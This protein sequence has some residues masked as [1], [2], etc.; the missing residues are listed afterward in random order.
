MN[1]ENKLS[2][3]T[4]RRLSVLSERIL[5]EWERRAVE[6]IPSAR[7]QSRLVLRD[8]LPAFMKKLASV[9]E[10]QES[11]NPVDKVAGPS[12]EHGQQRAE[13][14]EYSIEEVLREYHLLRKV[15]VEILSKE[16]GLVDSD[17]NLIDEALDEAM[18]LAGGEFTAKRE[19]IEKSYREELERFSSIAAHD[20]KEPLMAISLNAQVAVHESKKFQS[21]EV[22]ESLASILGAT[23]RMA[24]LIDSLLSLASAGGKAQIE[25]V[26]CNE[27]LKTVS[28]NLAQRIQDTH[29]EITYLNLPRVNG[30]KVQLLQLFQ[31][32]IANALKFSARI[33]TPKIL[34]V[35][36]D[37]GTEWLFSVQ[38]NGIGIEKRFLK[39]IFE[40]FRSLQSK[41]EYGGSGLGLAI[42][43][44]IVESHQGRIWAESELGQGSTFKFTF[45]K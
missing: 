29:A 23:K 5:Q 2:V 43:K 11:A 9:L 24:N 25:L 3:E 40:E 26:D 39:L 8:M 21:P 6:E 34:I 36:E 44:K 10:H 1:Q 42:C 15:I 16:G 17:R 33:R 18:V 31:N 14:F 13:I 19:A 22:S 37:R 32:L 27:I 12:R 20:L 7:E 45:P 41:S 30:D 4:A 38:D 35:S 28:I